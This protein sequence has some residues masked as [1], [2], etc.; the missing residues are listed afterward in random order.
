MRS[1]GTTRLDRIALSRLLKG[2]RKR[3]SVDIALRVQRARR[4]CA[5]RKPRGQAGCVVSPAERR[6]F[7]AYLVRLTEQSTDHRRAT[8]AEH[9][10][11][12]LESFRL[13]A[14][15]VREDDQ[16]ARAG[17]MQA[18]LEAYRVARSIV[19]LCS[20]RRT[21]ARPRP[22]RRPQALPV[23]SARR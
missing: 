13:A 7:R 17:L 18:R 15:E 23:R 3:V 20:I 21:L 9:L 2:E 16:I 12:R 4:R 19:A 10:R 8:L 22:Q 5:R 6:D 14:R 1:A 11:A